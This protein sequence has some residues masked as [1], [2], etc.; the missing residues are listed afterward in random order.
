MVPAPVPAVPASASIAGD[1]PV[2]VPQVALHALG[3]PNMAPSAAPN[4][5]P[6]A[7]SPRYQ[8]AL[9]ND[10]LGIVSSYLQQDNQL[11]MRDINDSVRAA[12][13]STITSLTLSAQ[14]ARALWSAPN[15]LH[16][17]REVRLTDCDDAD[18]Q[19]LAQAMGP[20]RASLLSKLELILDNDD[21][22]GVT[23]NGLVALAPLHLAGI[24]LK[25]MTITAADAFALSLGASPVSISLPDD[26]QAW[27][28]V[29][30]ICLI[31]TLRQLHA[32]LH[33][34]SDVTVVALRAHPAL[35]NLS[36]GTLSGAAVCELVA[37]ASIQALSVRHIVD[38]EVN[39]FTAIAGNRVLQSIVIGRVDHP[40]S[41]AIL[42]GNPVLTS[43]TLCLSTAA[44]NGIALLANMPSLQLLSLSAQQ[45][46]GTLRAADVQALCARSFATL[47]FKQWEIDTA[48]MAHIVAT[49]TPSLSLDDCYPV[50]HKAIEALASNRSLVSLSL[51]GGVINVHHAIMLA[52]SPTLQ[53]LR[54][55]IGDDAPDNA[56]D[57]IEIAWAVTNKPL[58]NLELWGFEQDDD[59]HPMEDA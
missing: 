4:A 55:E 42:S 35:T 18:L 33:H 27:S 41:L 40:E 47:Q 49:G 58:A 44:S 34:L 14:Q 6:S 29:P 23:A 43:V 36:V 9:T 11:E 39:V 52:T 10:E 22:N 7:I 59:N 38:G 21:R 48:A 26:G 51:L 3:A 37:S 50:T 46:S 31:P 16:N 24:S 12:V 20:V 1:S 25:G 53:F 28:D 30:G 45:A 56:Q 57:D 32:P 8:T 13:D 19:Q 2:H 15:A 54:A 17:L 5:A